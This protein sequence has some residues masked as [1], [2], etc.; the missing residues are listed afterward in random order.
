MSLLKLQSLKS[1]ILKLE[2]YSFTA[3]QDFLAE[4]LSIKA[5][6][7]AIELSKQKKLKTDAKVHR[8]IKVL[9]LSGYSIT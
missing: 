2:P 6:S 8:E 5:D 1:A 7:L 3:E 4:L 9:K